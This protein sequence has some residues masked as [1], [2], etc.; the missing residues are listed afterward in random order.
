MRRASRIRAS[1]RSMPGRLLKNSA[2]MLPSP[3]NCRTMLSERAPLAA[4]AEEPSHSLDPQCRLAVT[5]RNALAVLAARA[6][7]AHREVVAHGVDA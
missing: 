7:V 3:S 6:G 5:D 1:A 4:V 2:K